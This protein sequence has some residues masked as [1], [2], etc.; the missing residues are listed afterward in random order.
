MRRN[1][2]KKQ[3]K[4]QIREEFNAEVDEI[5]DRLNQIAKNNYIDSDLTDEFDS[6]P[7]LKSTKEA[8]RAKKFVKMS[9]IQ[10]QSLLF[11]LCGRDVIGAAET[12]TGKTLAFA[13]PVIEVLKKNKWSSHSGLG[14]II[15]SPTR[16]LAAQT[17]EVI[18][19]LIPETGLSVGLVTGGLDFEREQAALPQLNIMIAT[20]G[21]LKEHM[22]SS[23]T[24]N[25][26]NLQILVFDEADRLL[27]NEFLKDIKQIV[28]ELPRNRQTLL[29]TATANKAIKALS[30]ISL[31]SPVQVL[32]T[33]KRES[34][35]PDNLLQFYT[36]VPIS[37]KFNTLFSFLK[38]HK[39]NKM[40]VFLETIKMVRY[41]YEAFRH[42]KP[43]LPLLHL[44]GKQSSELRFTTCKDFAKKE[45]GV[46]FTT[47]V[48]ARGLDFPEVNWV[49]QMDCPTTIETY[50]HRVGR[51]ARFY[52]GGKALMFLAPSEVGIIPRLADA[53]VDIKPIQ[54]QESE[55]INIKPDLVDILAKFSDV[56][57][58]AIKAFT[59]YLK[60]VKR[61][62]DGEVFNFDEI[63]KQ[64]DEFARSFGLLG[65]PVIS[66][67][68]KSNEIIEMPTKQ[69]D[70]NVEE[71]DIFYTVVDDDLDTELGEKEE[72]KPKTLEYIG[73][74]CPI[75]EEEYQSWREYL[76]NLFKDQKNVNKG[77]WKGKKSEETEEPENIEDEAERLLMQ[78]LE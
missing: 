57:H 40:I 73:S 52:Q 35:T 29:F 50:I 60:S 58:L 10:K 69:N 48:A 12:G 46:I 5:N 56:K 11:S 62:N 67:K 7:I 22:N 4:Q 47:D 43:G 51:T 23:V 49:I 63:V 13:I 34:A 9:P 26:D 2:I 3:R 41:V 19:G 70:E 61:H 15:I 21:R 30:K 14:A 66:V 33:E 68:S 16:D 6:L 27:G 32:I 24:F 64:K 74:D 20:V 77:K 71:N 39:S 45:R 53:K 37:E 55:L 25:A 75:S 18:K 8:L 44:T 59:T 78:Q 17:Y 1:D 38:S 36:V 76:R 72:I 31:Q 42:L 65:T 54:I 28:K